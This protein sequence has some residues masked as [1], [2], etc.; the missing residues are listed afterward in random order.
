M[1]TNIGTT[2]KKIRLML[3]VGGI[4]LGIYL[5]SWW[6]VIGVIPL[7][8]SFINFCPLYALLGIN[9]IKNR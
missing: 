2:D 7:L 1:K 4:A 8:T 9:S 5:K 3:G 6:G